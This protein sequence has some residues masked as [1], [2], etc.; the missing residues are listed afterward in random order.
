VTDLEQALR[1]LEI[2]W[3]AT[4]DLATA[5][6][7]RITHA[8]LPRARPLRARFAWLGAALVIVL[9]GVAVVPDARSAVLRWLGL[10]GVEI[11]REQPR[12]TPPPR[13]PTG[14]TLGLGDRV[15]LAQ[16]R[17]GARVFVPAG[18]GAP[19]A[20]YRGELENGPEA[21]SLI[22][23]PSADIPASDVTGAGL[24][25]QTIPV[26]AATLIKKTAGAA[27]DVQFLTVDGSPAYW[28]TGSHGFAYESPE[29]DV[30]FEPERL[31]DRTL[32]VE[33]DGLLLRVEGKVSRD[34]AVQIAQDALS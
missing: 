26:S 25:V 7:E 24:L 1:E 23:A 12:A 9:G 32:L 19:S 20:V 8:A 33:R 22:Y 21:V 10:K 31:A 6:H 18:L 15:S 17:R 2:D 11:R 3:P 14:A 4:P 16:A 13:S 34:R 28:I 27:A 29:G 5:V 30:G